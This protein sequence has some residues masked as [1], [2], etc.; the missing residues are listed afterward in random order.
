MQNPFYKSIHAYSP[1]PNDWA[2]LSKDQKEEIVYYWYIDSGAVCGRRFSKD[3][4]KQILA[5]ESGEFD[6][7]LEQIRK[8]FHSVYASR[9]GLEVSVLELLG[10]TVDHIQRD[11]SRAVAH[12]DLIEQEFEK[13]IE[14][15]HYVRAREAKTKKEEVLKNQELRNILSLV[16]SFSYQKIESLRLL[17]EGNDRVQNFFSLFSSGKKLALGPLGGDLEEE[18]VEEKLDRKEAI[19]LL[20]EKLERVIPN[21]NFNSTGT[22][23]PHDGFEEFKEDSL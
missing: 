9:K 18:K 19:K 23:N 20:D 4:L 11:R 14:E 6:H 2:D 17:Y 7:I 1:N 10:K 5:L 12:S 8:D 21:T 13:L 16:K 15:Y 22:R 3:K